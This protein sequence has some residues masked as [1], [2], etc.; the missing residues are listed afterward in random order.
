M[1]PLPVCKECRKHPAYDAAF[2]KRLRRAGIRAHVMGHDS[3]LGQDIWMLSGITPVTRR[4]LNGLIAHNQK[5]G[6]KP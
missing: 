4:A 3:L 2:D 5:L 6:A 1:K